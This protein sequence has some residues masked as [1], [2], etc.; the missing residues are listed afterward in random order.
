MAKMAT[1]G[2]EPPEI[3]ARMRFTAPLDM[4][5]T[6]TLTLPGGVT[7]EGMPVGFQIAGASF[8][9]A[10]VLRAG[11]AFQRATQWHGRHPTL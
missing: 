6:P 10:K 1:T 5:G 3:R 11:H 9:E 7:A 4:A 8:A 2:R